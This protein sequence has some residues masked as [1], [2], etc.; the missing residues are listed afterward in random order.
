MFLLGLT[1][2]VFMHNETVMITQLQRYILFFSTAIATT[3][4]TDV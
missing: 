1:N 2:L 3:V 4:D